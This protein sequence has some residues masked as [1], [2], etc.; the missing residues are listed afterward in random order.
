MR[1]SLKIFCLAL[2]IFTFSCEQDLPTQLEFE[3][4][5]WSG[6]DNDVLS[7]K[8]ILVDPTK[9]SIPAPLANN[10]PTYL[11]EVENMK[12]KLAQLSPKNKEIAQQWTSNPIIR[13]NEIARELVAKYNLAPAPNADGTYPF[14]S[15]AN[16]SAY[17]NFPYAHPPYA[18]RMYAYLS[19][20]TYEA[21]LNAWKMKYRFNRPA[22]SSFISRGDAVVF[23]NGVPSYP[24][25]GA[26]IA[27]SA[28]RVLTAM[29]PLEKDFL[30][31]KVD[32]YLAILIPS[33][34][35]VQSDIDAGIILG[36]SV[37]DVALARASTDGMNRAQ[38]NLA[39]ADSIKAV[40][41]ARFGWE[42]KNLDIPER[43]IGLVARFGQ[44]KPWVVDDITK[45]RSALP[46][47]FES[48]QYKDA[49]VELENISKTLTNEQRKIAIFWA[50]GTNTYTPPGHWNRLAAEY[51]AESKMN[52]LRSARTLAYMNMAVMDAG[53]QCW[54]T[55]YY[56]HYP[57]P[58]QMISGFKTLLGTP[59]FPG[60][61][62]GHSTFSGAAAAVLSY[63]FPDKSITINQFA[64][65]A[66]ESRIYGGIHFRFDSEAGLE[67]GR[68][69]GEQCTNVARADLSR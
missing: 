34:Q 48:K 26:A 61:T 46:P 7:W 55:K 68:K 43:K 47:S 17:P 56:Y 22:T 14:P 10:D 45:F 24:S 49:V 5:T 16:P 3:D 13:W 21:T 37:A 58:N 42:F 64:K 40:A 19:V 65:E 54:D 32:E 25:H 44:V 38:T 6:I 41:R 33:G 12:S 29:F 69:I 60:Y 31:S 53:I 8:G 63:I 27:I 15:P 1:N 67:S 50:D 62:S 23:D 2:V 51:I 9:V 59:N 39:V 18:S 35:N 11:L 57:R 28:Q 36:N 66:S 20:A 52:P 30:Q 4:Y